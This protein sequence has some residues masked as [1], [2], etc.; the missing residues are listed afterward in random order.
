[1]ASVIMA[2]LKTMHMVARTLAGHQ[3]ITALR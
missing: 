3:A 2:M 1:M